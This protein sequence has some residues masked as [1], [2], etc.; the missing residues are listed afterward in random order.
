[1]KLREIY[2][3]L[4]NISPFELQEGWD[5]SGVNIGDLNRDIEEIYISLEV[6]KE[7]LEEA[8]ENSL[9]IVHHPLIF[10]S[11]KSIDFNLYPSNL[12]EIMIK[13]RISLIALHTNFDKSHLNRYVFEKVLGF[14]VER[15][16]D[17]ILE[18]K[19]DISSDKLFKLLKEKLNLKYLKVVNG[20][21][22]IDSIALTT[23]SGASLIDKINSSCFLTGDIKYH[24]A[25]KA[26]SQDLML[27]DIGHFES[28][29]FF[30]EIL[31]EE[32]ENLGIFAIIC[33]FKNPFEL[34]V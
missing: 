14:K 9:F 34:I 1:M 8:R 22:N 6:T 18:S 21:E 25:M 29:I 12:I 13:K 33:E 23:G 26:K 5:N 2:N 3:I 19:I 17:F 11:L 20:K 31:K 27:I 32:L 30:S 15:E 16:R 28:E 4:D 7:I 10:S 24:D